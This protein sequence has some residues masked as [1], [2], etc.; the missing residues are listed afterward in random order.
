MKSRSVVPRG[1]SMGLAV[2]RIWPAHERERI[3]KFCKKCN[4]DTE[5]RK[6]GKCKLCVCERQAKYRAANSER[7]RESKAKYRADNPEWSRAASAKQYAANPEKRRAASARYRAANPDKAR[8]AWMKWHAAN[9]EANRIVQQNRRARKRNNGG[10]LSP[11]LAA[12]LFKF[13]RGKCACCRVSLDDGSHLDHVIPLAL[14]GPNEDW[15]MQLLCGPCNLSK[16]AKHPVEFM[17]S[18]GFLL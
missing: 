2:S 18:R 16:G 4:A 1:K 7:L 6:D 10:K 9:P 11:G 8:D 5:R 3:M 14:D 15:N 12:K 13:Q 17:Q